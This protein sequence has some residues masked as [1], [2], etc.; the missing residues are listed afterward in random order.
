VAFSGNVNPHLHQSAAPN[1]NGIA[2]NVQT[3]IAGVPITTGPLPKTQYVAA[4]KDDRLN[5]LRGKGTA[6]GWAMQAQI[7]TQKS[8]MRLVA[9]QPAKNTGGA[10]RVMQSSMSSGAASSGAALGARYVQVGTFGNQGNVARV[11]GALA[12]MGLPVAKSRMTKAGRELVIVL[13]GPFDSAQAA[14]TALAM[15]HQ[16]GF[17]DAFMR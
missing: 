8:P 7:W 10:L 2:G 9:N 15:A 3:V 13:A 6:E 12:A 14:Q 1:E 4:W 16:A 5:P 11:A 17:G